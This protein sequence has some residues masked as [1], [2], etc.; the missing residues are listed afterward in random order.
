MVGSFLK[1]GLAVLKDV[2]FKL[3]AG[4]KV[5]FLY[6]RWVQLLKSKKNPGYHKTS[7]TSGPRSLKIHKSIPKQKHVIIYTIDWSNNQ[8]TIFLLKSKIQARNGRFM[9]L[10]DM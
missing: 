8:W 7:G 1:I 4:A 10:K 3:L 5:I 2:A 9:T 6:D